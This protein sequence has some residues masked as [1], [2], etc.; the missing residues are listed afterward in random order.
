MKKTVI[1]VDPLSTG[2]LLQKRVLDAGLSIIIVWSDRSQPCA[3]GKHFARS[4][5]T[6]QQFQCLSV[7]VHEEGKL[8]DTVQAIT[9][10]EN[11]EIVALMCGSEFGVLL[12]DSL[13][14][15]LNKAL[16]TTHLRSSGMTNS[17]CKV[18]K[19]LQAET[20]RKAGLASIHQQLAHCD[21]H[22]ED[23]LSGQGTTFKA[24]AKPQTGA[25]SVGVTFCDSPESVWKAY[26]AILEGSHKAHCGDK[27]RHYAKA[28]VLLQEYLEGTEYIVNAVA[29]DG[30]TKVTAIW[31]YDKRPYNGA[32]FVCYSKFLLAIDDEPHLPEIVE[33]TEKILE[34]LHFRNGSMHAEIMYTADR[35][36]VLV[37][38]NCRLHGGNGAWV[39]PVEHCMGYSQLS[40][41][42]DVYMNNGQGVF[43]TIPRVPNRITGGCYVVKMRTAVS[44]ILES[45]V[46][47]QLDRIKALSSYKEHF[48]S[49][50]EGEFLNS[51]IDM[52][53][54]PGEVTLVHRE[55]EVLEAD[56]QELNDILHEGLFKVKDESSLSFPKVDV[57]KKTDD[58]IL[59]SSSPA[60]TATISS[61][62]FSLPSPV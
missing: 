29:C 18:D 9:R 2:A 41:M 1:L 10:V 47:S 15:A 26:R 38:T 12:E 30:E 61:Y 43:V 27:Y 39:H 53:T 21:E 32:P 13:A 34:A 11:A 6:A 33:Y 36:P 7:V 25:G 60:D 62:S 8:D 24:V 44:G 54:V 35:G 50:M 48:F 31:K 58:G 56:Y 42:M 51:T 23:F 46:E 45:V 57:K 17:Q 5:L 49:V 52:P 3:R 20:I 28:G 59:T 37:E 22:V 14:I 40:V 55:K 19:Y 16:G 4:G